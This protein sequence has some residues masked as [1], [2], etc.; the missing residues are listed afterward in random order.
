MQY[1]FTS[2]Q[3][4]ILVRLILFHMITD[5]ILQPDSWVK[6]KNQN[7][8]KSVQLYLHGFLAALGAYLAF[9][10]LAAFPA[11]V[12]VLLTHISL[13]LWKSYQKKHNLGYFALDQ[14]AHIAI[15]V[16]C[17][18]VWVS[19]FEKMGHIM[20]C[21]FEN[22]KVMLLVLG[23]IICI[24]PAG[25][26]VDLSTE[27][28]LK[29]IRLE[30]NSGLSEVGKWIGIIE[31]ILVFT[32]VFTRNYENIGLIL[33]AK[34]ILR[35]SDAEVRKNTEYVLIGTMISFTFAIVTGLAIKFLI[36]YH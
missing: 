14:L 9:R 7:H 20:G 30:E 23:Y 27:R 19:G 22:Y 21:L 13:D 25:Y 24:Y 33:A 17:W 12:V 16:M 8:Y 35:F 2:E 31:R 5:F 4:V 26:I 10:D 34:S 32:M 3:G 28:W 36:S 15:L 11:F 29:Q 18:L 6:H 1:E